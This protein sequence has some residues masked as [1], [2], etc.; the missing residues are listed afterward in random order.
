[1]IFHV[2]ESG[3]LA[4]YTINAG[5]L[6]EAYKLAKKLQTHKEALLTIGTGFKNGKILKP[7]KT[8]KEL[9]R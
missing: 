6:E 5:S 4:H 7:F 1:M 9:K 2:T 8:E 3:V